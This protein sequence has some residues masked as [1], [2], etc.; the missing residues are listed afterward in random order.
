MAIDHFSIQVSDMPRSIEFYKKLFGMTVVSED[1]PKE[2]ARMGY[3]KRV[4]ISLHRKEP[5]GI[6]DHYA[7]GVENF[8]Q[9]ALAEKLA[10]RGIS[11][12][13]SDDAGFHVKDPDGVRVQ[14]MRAGAAPSEPGSGV[15]RIHMLHHVNTQVSDVPRSEAFYRSLFGFG[16]SR[17]VQGPDNHGLDFPKGGLIILQTSKSPGRLD[18]FCLGASNFD[19]TRMRAEA[20][21]LFPGKVQGT[22][23][24]NFS[25]VDPDGVRVQV[26]PPD[27]SA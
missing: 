14:I 27:W 17:R 21:E 9:K 3:G 16:P 6:I 19:A 11:A 26:S 8:D 7:I 12:S 20:G 25:V 15:V 4:L 5:Y 2:I 13:D 18:H 1:R 22:A 23:K 10:A 24:D